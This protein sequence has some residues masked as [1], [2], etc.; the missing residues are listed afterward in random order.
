MRGSRS[1]IRN[2]RFGNGGV[3]RRLRFPL[4]AAELEVAPAALPGSV[5]PFHLG[6]AA[7]AT[8]AHDPNLRASPDEI[9]LAV[10]SSG[11]WARTTDLRVMSPTL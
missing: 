4:A 9:L 3:T 8:F 7:P 6:R 10:L 11:G 1:C 2:G 5:P